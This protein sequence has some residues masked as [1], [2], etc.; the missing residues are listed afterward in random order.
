MVTVIIETATRALTHYPAPLD[1]DSKVML[2]EGDGYEAATLSD[3]DAALVGQTN[4]RYSVDAAGRLVVTPVAVVPVVDPDDELEAAIAGATTLEG[5]KAA[6]L[7]KNR[8]GKVKGQ[9]RA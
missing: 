3:A 9:P 2:P 8:A 7:G 5:L 4:A 6:L 1:R